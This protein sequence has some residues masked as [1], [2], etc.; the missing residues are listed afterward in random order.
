MSII[1][2]YDDSHD[3]LQEVYIK[4][5]LAAKNYQSMKKPLAWVYTIAKNECNIF[6]RRTHYHIEYDDKLSLP[7]NIDMNTE[8]ILEKLFEVLNDQ[9]REIIVMHSLWGL[10][11]IEIADLLEIPLSTSLSCHHRGMKKMKRYLEEER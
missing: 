8:M 4:I 5:Y 3:I 9:E 10:K 7:Q 11:Y 1:K 2:N 6:L